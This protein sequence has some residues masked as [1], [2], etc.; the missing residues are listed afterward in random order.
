MTQYGN[1]K[2]GADCKSIRPHLKAI[3]SLFDIEFNY[4]TERYII[5]F[6]GSVFQVVPWK[7][8]DKDTIERIRRV[9]W[10]NIN[11]D[12]FAE[13]D[14]NNEKIEQAQEAQRQDMIHELAK[15]LKWAINKEF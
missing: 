14:A 9:Y 4:D 10:E 3:D 11:S 6:N 2:Y 15:D 1:D 5:Y 7:E 13:V 8:L 12:P